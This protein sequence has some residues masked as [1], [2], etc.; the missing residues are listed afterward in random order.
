ML[1]AAVVA[2][3]LVSTLIVYSGVYP[4]GE[5]VQ[6]SIS[7]SQKNQKVQAWSP[8]KSASTD[9]L[10][11]SLHQLRMEALHYGSRR[12]PGNMEELERRE[13]VVLKLAMAYYAD[14]DDG[15]FRFS[16]VILLNQKLRS[17]KLG[18]QDKA[19]VERCLVRS[20]RD[21]E[22][23]VRTEG[24]WGLQFTK[25]RALELEVR[26]LLD[27]PDEEVRSYAEQTLRVLSSFAY[28]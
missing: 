2:A 28:K 20:L 8:W 14:Q 6:P 23:W 18:I 10:I 25:N 15:L 9:E 3:V 24:V 4:R 5:S 16:L 12:M 17:G 7:S 26:P 21:K 19:V 1:L 11:A 27:D 22:P 13:N